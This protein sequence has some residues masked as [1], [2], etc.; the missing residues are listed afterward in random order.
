MSVD[1]S[2]IETSNNDQ[3][4]ITSGN[5]NVE[6]GISED[7]SVKHVTPTK[8][9]IN[10][11]ITPTKIKRFKMVWTDFYKLKLLEAYVLYCDNPML[12]GV[13]EEGQKQ[14]L[15]DQ[16]EQLKDK[17][18]WYDGKRCIWKLI[19]RVGTMHD[20][21]YR[22]GFSAQRWKDVGSGSGNKTTGLYAFMRST[23]GEDVSND[24]AKKMLPYLLSEAEKLISS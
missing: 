5:I 10:R 16:I 15:F 17:E 21:M 2:I 12:R 13:K 1:N 4:S 18:L 14:L 8:G 9:N 22:A 20:K 7:G 24:E 23:L 11:I 19:T 6:M 3:Y